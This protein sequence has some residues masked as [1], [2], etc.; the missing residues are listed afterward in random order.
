M[1]KHHPIPT[2]DLSAQIEDEQQSRARLLPS[3][4]LSTPSAAGELLI[5]AKAEAGHGGWLAWVAA[6]L[7]ISVSSMPRST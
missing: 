5:Q 7:T 6:N 4:R 1:T 3:P 2:I